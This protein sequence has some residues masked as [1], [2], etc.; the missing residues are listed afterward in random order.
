MEIWNWFIYFNWSQ[1]AFQITPLKL[2]MN[3]LFWKVSFFL[4]D[5]SILSTHLL[6]RERTE[7]FA[8][9]SASTSSIIPSVGCNAPLSTGMAQLDPEAR[10]VV[11]WARSG[12]TPV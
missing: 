10:A 6:R 8:K 3:L 5:F 7:S 4:L 11:F 1:F 9:L 12:F 2:L